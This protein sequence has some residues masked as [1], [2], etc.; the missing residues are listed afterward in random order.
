[1]K[2]HASTIKFVIG[3]VLL[4]ARITDIIEGQTGF[5]SGA[6]AEVIGYNVAIAFSYIG[7]VW[8]IASA[9]KDLRKN[10]QTDTKKSVD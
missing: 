9:I 5:A 8:L 10:N 3:A 2:K 7:G 6:G 4:I 1:M